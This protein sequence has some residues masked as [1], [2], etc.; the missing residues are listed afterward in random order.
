VKYARHLVAIFIIFLLV[1]SIGCQQI[2]TPTTSKTS[3]STTTSATPINTPTTITSVT[4]TSTQ[5][6]LKVSFIDVGQADCT[7][8]QYGN[9]KM[10]IDA[11]GNSTANS[12]VSKIKN[13]GINKFDV[14]VGTHPHEDHIGGMDAVID[15]KKAI[16]Q[17]ITYSI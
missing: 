11:G 3:T 5:T 2:I 7:I 10:I 15:A 14:V 17:T 16:G 1:I 12:L 9:S 8:I 6:T 13:M 4:T